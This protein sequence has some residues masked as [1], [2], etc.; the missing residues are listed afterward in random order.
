MDTLEA[1]LT[2]SE[3]RSKT[4]YKDTRGFWSIGVG[5]C[6]DPA[7]PGV[8]LCD[9]AIQAQL[10]HDKGYWRDFAQTHIPGFSLGN[11]VQQDVLA[12]MCFQLGTLAGWPKFKA[13]VA[14]GDFVTAA[15]EALDSKWHQET[16]ARAEREAKMLATGLWLDP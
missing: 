13:A 2:Q 15:A 14:K 11:E 12:S 6:V 3:G 10:D 7:V 4:V 9:A 8:G 5:C 1:L 16:P